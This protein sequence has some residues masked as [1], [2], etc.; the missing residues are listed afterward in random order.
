MLDFGAMKPVIEKDSATPNLRIELSSARWETIGEF[1]LSASYNV[2][3]RLS[4][5]HSVIKIGKLAAAEVFPRVH[6]VGLLPPRC[7]VRLYPMETPFRAL[8]CIFDQSFFESITGIE[9]ERWT[10]H[11]EAFLWIRNNR[12]ETMMR[13]FTQSLCSRGLRPKS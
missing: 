1:S 10:E 7:S 6:S 8:N 11:P 5:G 9:P 12:I 13:R 3:Q 4:H 2:C